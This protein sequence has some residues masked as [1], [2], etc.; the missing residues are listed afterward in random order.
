MGGRRGDDD[1]E[2][3]EECAGGETRAARLTGF[4][5]TGGSA[6]GNPND[7][8]STFTPGAA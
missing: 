5:V 3:G 7:V 1:L 2:Q 6:N 4:T 8:T